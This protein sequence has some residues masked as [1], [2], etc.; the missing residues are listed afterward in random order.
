MIKRIVLFS[1]LLTGVL[2]TTLNSVAQQELPTAYST[3]K[4]NSIRTWDAIKPDTNKNNF[5]VN[6]SMAVATMATQYFDGLGRPIQTV[7]KKGSM[8]TGSSPVDLVSPV[9]YD[10]FGREQ[11]KY[12]PFAANATGGNNHLTDGLFK[13]NP[14]QQ[15]TA[16]NKAMF[17]DE[18]YFYGRTVFEA[19]EL[20]R[21]LETF[22]PGNSWVG[23]EGQSSESN[24]RSMKIKYWLNKTADS[25]RVWTV[26]D[27]T[28]SFGTYATSVIY[29]AGQLNK[30][31]TTDEHGKQV[32]EF[33]DKEGLV[34]LKKVQLTAQ[35][36]TGLGK[37]H[38]GWLC[39]YYIYDQLNRLRGVIQPKGVELLANSWA[40]TSTI[41]DEQCFRYEYDAK[42]R[43]TVKKVPGAG[44][45]WMVYDKRD[46]LVMTQ[47]SVMRS[48]NQWLYTQYD[49]LNRPVATG[50]FTD[51]N[52][53]SYHATRADT[54]SSYPT[55]GTYTID[56]LT[57][58]FYDDYA[59]RN[60]QGNPLSAARSTTYDGYLQ[61]PSN[62]IWPYPQ[63]AAVQS[64]Q[65]K[66]MVTGTKIKI[67]GTSTYL[68]TVIFYDDKARV[69][70]TQL[71]N[72]TDSVDIITTQYV[73][74][75]QTI[76][77]I[78]KS[79]K[80]GANAQ[81]SIILT[82]FTYDSLMRVT[83]V[84]KRVSNTKVNNGS[85]PGSW[86][87]IAHNEYDAL[88]QLKK[89]KLGSDPLDSLKYDY[90]I[91]G[92]MLG[93]NR[94]Y[95]K[96][97]GNTSNY[98]GFDLGYNK[99]SIASIGSFAAA[100]YNGNITGIVW[101][102][103]GDNEIRKYD[104]TYDAANRILSADFNQYTSGSF[105]KNANVDFSM[106][107]MSYDANG[108]ILTMKQR[109]LKIGGSYTI[110]SLTY[111]YI[112]GSNR[113][114]NVIDGQNDATTKLG[115]F[116]TSTLH[117]SSGSKGSG[118]TD[119]T[120]DG[121]GNM[122]KDLNKDIATYAG[123]D[124]IEYN[125]LNLP[126]KITVRKNDNNKG[127]IEYT[128]DAAGTKLKRTVYEPGVDT[129][130][131][132]YLGELVFKN[133]TLEFIS[134]E[135]GRI[136]KKDSTA[137]VYDYFLKDHLGNV[138]MVLTQQKD[139]SVY[140]PV[141]H[142]YPAKV[143]EDIFYE[144]VYAALTARPGSFYTEGTNGDTVQLL[145]KSS[146]SIGTGKLIKVMAKDK[147]HVKVDYYTP[148]ETT[149]NSG[150]DGVES[151]LSILTNLLNNSSATS[152]LHGGGS[153][154]TDNLENS[155]P[156][157]DFLAP[158]SGSG[159][160]NPKAY[161]NILFFDEQFKFVEQ[162]SEIVQINVKG[163]GQTITRI[164]GSAKEAV[165]NGYVYIYVSNESNNF[166]YFDNLQVKHERGP[167]LEETH[168]YP[169]GLTMAGI[170]SKALNFGSPENKKKKF[171][172]QEYNDDLGVNYYEYRYR[173]HDPQIGRFIQID[174]LANDYLYN[175][176]YAFSGNKVSTHI[177][178]EGLEEA[179]FDK[180]EQADVERWGKG[181]ITTNEMRANRDARARAGLVG[182][183]IVATVYTGGRLG[184]GILKY[185]L[186][187][188]GVNATVSALQ[189]ESGYEIFKSAVSGFISG[190][191]LGALPGASWNALITAGAA[192]GV[193]GEVTEQTI[194]M[195]V[196]GNRS[197]FDM[198]KMIESGLLGA[199][200]N[201]IASGAIKQ[202]NQVLDKKLATEIATTKTAGYRETIKNAI[203]KESPG[204][205]G[206][207]LT[208]SINQRIK[209]AQQLIRKQ[210]KL[211][212][213]AVKQA[214]ERTV[215]ALQ[216]LPKD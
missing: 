2:F 114:L 132:L 166:V 120:Y 80:A 86:T 21:P 180:R 137:L 45:V 128:Y 144:N 203:K 138:R 16:F 53:L 115:D 152:V 60:G 174:P 165:K 101:K 155:T 97:S 202:V 158:Q 191:V 184:P 65:T 59:W 125:Y 23:T 66:E 113:L 3:Y 75:G 11:Y 131:T 5:T 25:V 134:H 153:T 72:I 193:A 31:I 57:K 19:S 200:A 207:T 141:T 111:N 94:E 69:I 41:L 212:R 186:V 95:A 46:R 188:A 168:Y 189:G 216:N 105:N 173:N 38:S 167:I 208:K 73:W 77:T 112:T 93:M 205:S 117:P 147:V 119:Y 209:Q 64:N 34:V 177:E 122:V 135:E 49:G 14:F 160:T 68:Y 149:N 129:T 100:Q 15:D 10:E 22:A 182:M 124:G 179:W 30:T 159:G 169:F 156:F 161:L 215:D 206:K 99:T 74:T 79:K 90:N 183:A 56:T 51:N 172:G 29:G 84:E 108:N 87:T 127:T 39:T 133:D 82:Q 198:G 164:E 201:V 130:V 18:T 121:N 44:K 43:M 58:T 17:S 171:Q 136:R 78:D 24:R 142:E 145:R 42:N 48:N 71:T 185:A 110:D 162:N 32:I 54:S 7:V 123:A 33:K 170:S 103:R 187:G 9:T 55:A 199:V 194:D 163:S 150:A 47:D 88:E 8:I 63:N 85:M 40:M 116:R 91:L 197:N 37:N 50:I 195:F 192:S 210:D 106:S 214:I 118:T 104:F 52:N 83:K 196:G 20:S 27:V 211:E 81:T 175:S 96:S 26:T 92:W 61:E 146:Q 67:L 157:T 139:T 176:T 151:I 12:L 190:A 154:I 126:K 98:F 143:T 109:G 6:S 102:S 70:Q 89:K 213:A 148:N 178:L 36:D 140:P 28:N 107:G 4:I 76:L 181:E 1:S 35:P 62:T 13:V 204:M